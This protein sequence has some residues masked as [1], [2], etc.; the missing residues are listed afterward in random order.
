MVETATHKAI[1]MYPQLNND[2]NRVFYCRYS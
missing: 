1:N 2:Q